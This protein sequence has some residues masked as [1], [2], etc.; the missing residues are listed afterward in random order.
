MKM[1][2]TKVK[3]LI[4]GLWN[5]LFGFLIF[6]FL[7]F[8]FGEDSSYLKVLLLTYFIAG[9]NSYLVQK[10][11]VWQTKRNIK[12]EFSMFILINIISVALNYVFLKALMS[13]T[14]LDLLL[15]QLISIALIASLNFIVFD[16]VI[17][18][19]R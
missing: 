13:Q 1:Q 9:I 5:T 18:T 12:K 17:F 3:F 15:S 8:V 19:N 7:T 16:R 4:A 6:W 2:S 10:Y 11:L 14:S